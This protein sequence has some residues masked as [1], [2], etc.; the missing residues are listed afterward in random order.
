ME[1]TV[2]V[3]YQPH[4]LSPQGRE[5]IPS[6]WQAGRTIR[7]HL[8]ACGVD[9]Q[10]EV[11]IYHNTRLITVSEWDVVC[12]RPGDFLHVEGVVSG[13]GDGSNPIAAT[14]PRWSSS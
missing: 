13:G 7:A 9:A 6:E 12:P 3:T 5:V 4:P 1:M 8:I 10:R 2:P 14:M 11:V